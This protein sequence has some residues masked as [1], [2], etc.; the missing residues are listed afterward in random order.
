MEMTTT[1]YDEKINASEYDIVADSLTEEDLALMQEA[2]RNNE[3]VIIRQKSN[4]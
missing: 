1:K 3:P 4:A 2:A